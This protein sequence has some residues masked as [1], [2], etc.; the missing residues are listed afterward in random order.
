MTKLFTYVGSGKDSK[1]NNTVLKNRTKVLRRY[2]DNIA[3]REL[4]LLFAVQALVTQRQ[5]PKGICFYI[6]SRLDFLTFM[7]AGLIQGIFET[8]YDSNVVSEESFESWACTDDPLEREDKAVALQ[9][10]KSFFTWLKEADPESDEDEY[11]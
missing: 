1:L 8:L 3:D 6:V 11:A 10:M 9:M 7:V 4:Q 2:V 5:H